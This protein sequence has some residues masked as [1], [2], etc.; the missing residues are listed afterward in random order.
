MKNEVNFASVLV[1][2]VLLILYYPSVVSGNDQVGFKR[3]FC[4]LK[5]LEFRDSSLLINLVLLTESIKLLLN[6]CLLSI[7]LH[8][9][10]ILNFYIIW[11]L[12]L[13]LIILSHFQLILEIWNLRWN[14][15]LV[16]LTIFIRLLIYNSIFQL[17]ILRLWIVLNRFFVLFGFIYFNFF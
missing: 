12:S 16:L 8:F 4:L 9:S 3:N 5:C 11:N 15:G 2:K 1:N 14:C 10:R 7:I 17:V 13:W 6:F